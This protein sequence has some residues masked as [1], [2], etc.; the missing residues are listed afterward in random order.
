MGDRV[1]EVVVTG[2]KARMHHSSS[3]TKHSSTSVLK[4]DVELAVTLVSILDLGGK[5]VS[6]RDG[7]CGS[8]VSTRKVLGSSGVLASGHSND[9][10]QCSEKNDLDKSEGGDVCKSRESHTVLENISERVISGKIEGSREGN[11]KLLNSHTYESNH[12][13]TS[14]LD[15]NSTTTREALKI[16]DVSKR[17]EEVKRTRVNSESIGGTS[18]SVQGGVESLSLG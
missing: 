9:L 10:S 1:E 7:S 16:I 14:V 5:G 3:Y 4:L 2:V 11:S 17:I 15:L 18:I 8:V 13:N 6:S 12:G